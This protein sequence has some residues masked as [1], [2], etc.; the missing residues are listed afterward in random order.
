MRVDKA[1]YVLFVICLVVIPAF[2]SAATI[3]FDITVRERTADGD[4]ILVEQKPLTIGEGI[5]TSSF[6]SNF[7]LDLEATHTDSGVFLCEFNLYTVGPQSQTIF[8]RFHSY[9][10]G[11]YFIDNVRVK[12]GV[13]YRVGISPVSYD[14][15]ATVGD[16][17]EYN[18]REQGI[19]KFDPAAHMDLYYISRTLGD[20][21]WNMI[22]D[23]L[24]INYKD[25]K[26][27][28]DPTFP[29][30]VNCFLAPCILPEVTWDKRSGYAID[31][32]RFNCFMLYSHQYH[33]IDPF[34][35]YLVRIYRFMGYAPPILAEGL[36]AYYDFPHY[37]AKKL[38]DKNE[39]PPLGSMLKS[40]D[41]Y[42]LP[43]HT[44]ITAASSFANYMVQV[45]GYNRFESL[46][47]KST[48]LTIQDVFMDVYDKSL[49]TLEWEWRQMLDTFQVQ[50][51]HVRYFYE[52]N[53]YIYN[54]LGMDTFIEEFGR[55]GSTKGD[56]IF[57]LSEKAW[58]LYM[59]GEYDT[60]RTLY[61]KLIPLDPKNA[62]HR[63]VYG[64]LLL[65]DGQYDSAVGAYTELY[66]R[67][68]TVKTSFYKK[69]EAFW[70][71]GNKDSAEYYF[72]KDITD[73]P[74]QLSQASSG[75]FMGSIELMKGDTSKAR[76]YYAGALDA[77]EHI[78]KFGRTR[79]GYL[80]R[81]GQAHMG[82]AMCDNIPLATA[83]SF[84]E[85]ARYFEIHPQRVIF[86]TRIL[87]ELGKIAD[88]EGNRDKAIAL[89]QEA[90]GYPLSPHAA[91]EV[92]Q[93][94]TKPFTGYH[95]E[96]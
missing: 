8:K 77:M 50:I 11:V 83:R 17:C 60:A 32:S 27:T 47:Q 55:L 25:F 96:E 30:K 66:Y 20:A 33:T 91:A 93:Y 44:N 24:E 35:V 6:I 23:Y 13:V 52:K 81:L 67:D 62:N 64:N 40:I 1:V 18:Y 31:P 68:S 19:W 56:T 65:I 78:Y 80:L 59:D 57:Y 95:A 58:S 63:M 12:N 53:E 42:N 82:L 26:K 89:Y 94:L 71:Q 29:G 43:G 48:D 37:Y 92:R 15:T 34:P 16:G 45:Y 86:L 7:T 54:R 85:Q 87:R 21:R 79:P 49:D 46:Y 84:L 69:G 70:Y 10:G 75:I 90:M 22:R 61:E 51:G 3:D 76:D 39:L 14:S 28:L 88:L 38:L 5:R 9:L 41:Y 36:A 4:Y 74:S 2:I 72:Y 73:D